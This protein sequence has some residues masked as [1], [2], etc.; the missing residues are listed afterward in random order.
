L[1]FNNISTRFLADMATGN[2]GA[3]QV[4]TVNN[5]SPI[6]KA[7]GVPPLKQER[8]NNFSA[9]ITL[10]PFENL[11]VTADAYLIQ[12]KDRIVLSS[13]FPITNAVVRDILMPFPGVTQAQF[14]ANAVDT[15][16]RGLDVV[17]D[18]AVDTGAGTVTLSAA[19]NFTRTLVDGDLHIPPSLRAAFGDTGEAAL[20]T[21][22]FGRLATSQMED[23]VPRQ[24][25]YVSARYNLR[26]LSALV[27]ANYYGKVR[28]QTDARDG[29]GNFLDERFSAKTLFDVD[30]GYQFTKNLQLSVGADN[31]LNTFPD[32]QQKPGNISFGRFIYSRAVSQFG[33]NGGCYYGKLELTFF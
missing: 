4:L 10:R 13:T 30:L 31:L 24:K 2:L 28:F 21:F 32:Q 3:N 19:A 33:Q 29:N 27:R 12:I 18:Y 6:A 15:E 8:S 23:A 16:T 22:L 11:S 20:R 9:G 25:G 14:F 26:G 5:A 1:W 7:F 17:A